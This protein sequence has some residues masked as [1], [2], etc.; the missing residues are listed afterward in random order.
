MNGKLSYGITVFIIAHECSA[1]FSDNT[2]TT[3]YTRGDTHGCLKKKI[4]IHKNQKCK[5]MLEFKIFDVTG[6]S[7]PTY[8]T[9]RD[10]LN[11]NIR[12]DKT[13]WTQIFD[14]TRRSETFNIMWTF[15]FNLRSSFT[16]KCGNISRPIY[17]YITV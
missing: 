2:R 12:R 6:Q 16:W 11:P 13:I 7:E 10:N 4:K 17:I 9:W 8:S 1:N 15:Y 3:K 5:A 14:V